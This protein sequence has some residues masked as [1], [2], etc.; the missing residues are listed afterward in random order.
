MKKDLIFTDKCDMTNLSD[1]DMYCSGVIHQTK[2]IVD[3]TG[4]E[5]AA[6][7]YMPMDG[8]SAPPP[9]IDVYLDYIVD[10]TFGYVITDYNGTILFSG[11]VNTI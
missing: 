7:T 5:G 8:T 3:E 10:R 9:V 2:L 1:I 11:V 4:I 6:I